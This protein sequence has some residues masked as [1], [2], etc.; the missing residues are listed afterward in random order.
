LLARWSAA[1][2][3]SYPNVRGQVFITDRIVDSNREGVDLVF[4]IGE[5]LKDHRSS[6]AEKS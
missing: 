6:R 5:Q 3:A 4:K 1:S 2:K